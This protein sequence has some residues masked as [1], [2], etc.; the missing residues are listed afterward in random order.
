MMKVA[1]L[2]TCFNRKDKTVACLDALFKNKIDGVSLRVFLVD[3]AS[4][5]GTAVEVMSRFPSVELIA[6]RGDLFWNRGMCR[7]FEQSLSVGFDCYLWLN[8]DTLLYPGALQVLLNAW[9]SSMRSGEEGIYI[10]ST[11]D[12][13]TLQLTYGGVVRTTRWKP[14]G[15]RL[16]V[17]T[18]ELVL[19]HTMNGN[20]VLIPHS[21]AIRVGNLDQRFVHAMGDTDYGLRAEKL[22]IRSWVVPGYVGTC[23]RNGVEGTF[24]DPALPFFSRLKKMMATKGLPPKSWLLI[25]SRH[26]GFLWPIFFVWPYFKRLINR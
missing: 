2:M 19:C 10:G 20:C 22:G 26:G 4:T 9:A 17:P 14:L 13:H 5:D 1:V 18:D 11:Q 15:F 12:E 3:D 7:A 16:V 25:T 6:G 8:D 24:N 23:G 21:V